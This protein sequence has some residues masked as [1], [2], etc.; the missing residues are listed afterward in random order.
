MNAVCEVWDLWMLDV[1]HLG[2]WF[3]HNNFI[4]KIYYH[5]IPLSVAVSSF[6]RF[7]FSIICKMCCLCDSQS[8]NVSSN[9][10]VSILNEFLP[11]TRWW[12]Q[13]IF[14][15]LHFIN[16]WAWSISTMITIYLITEIS[17]ISFNVLYHI[18]INKYPLQT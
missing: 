5:F 3:I 4:F 2:L 6:V 16:T 11:F 14:N 18:F 8:L 17:Y 13:S 15:I 7:I 10:A 12:M 9:D 1:N